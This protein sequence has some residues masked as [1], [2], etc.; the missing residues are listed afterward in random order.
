MLW[1]FLICSSSEKNNNVK[2]HFLIKQLPWVIILLQSPSRPPS[3]MSNSLKILV[4]TRMEMVGWAVV[5][6]T[7]VIFL[8]SNGISSIKYLL[9]LALIYNSS[10]YICSWFCFYS[11]GYL[12][13]TVAL[14]MLP[15]RV[16]QSCTLSALSF[17][18]NVTHIFSVLLIQ[19]ITHI[20]T[21]SCVQ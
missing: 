4:R 9:S 8:K 18:L 1:I 16:S 19:V 3:H 17:L 11:R 2:S 15:A 6:S 21:P 13:F 14:N 10:L 20:C 12:L 7:H 5:V